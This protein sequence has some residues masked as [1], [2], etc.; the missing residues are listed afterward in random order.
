MESRTKDEYIEKF[1][2]LTD[3][4]ISE[5]EIIFKNDS[6][7]ISNI[8][9]FKTGLSAYRIFGTK[10]LDIFYTY[11]TEHRKMIFEKDDSF[12]LNESD[13]N[14]SLAKSF[15]IVDNWESLIEDNKNAIWDYFQKLY[16]Y[17]YL[18]KG[19]D[20]KMFL[21]HVKN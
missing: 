5:L 4:F 20:P 14:V 13:E 8:S 3:K 21:E 15:G 10:H 2:N 16:L 9:L 19:N 1:D 18:A 6:K 17:S 12:L 7:T 11:L